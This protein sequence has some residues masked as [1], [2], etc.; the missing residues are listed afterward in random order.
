MY[1]V[2]M[3]VW[4]GS[5]VLAGPHRPSAAVAAVAAAACSVVLQLW[6]LIPAVKARRPRHAG[7]L[8][9]AFA[10]INLAA[11]PVI[12]ALW[13]AAGEQLAVL[14]AVYLAPRW[15]VPAVAA[16]TAAPTAMAL[17]GHD[18]ASDR[19]FAQ[20]TPYWALTMGLL[21][22]LARTAARLRAGQQ[23]LAGSAVV[24]E[25][26]RIDEELRVAL[27][28]ELE[29][30]VA[31]GQHAAR[32]AGDD[33]VAAERELRALTAASRRALAETRRMVSRYQTIT[34]RS[35]VTAAVALLAAAGIPVSVDVPSAVLGQA[36]DSQRAAGFRAALTAVLRDDEAHPCVITAD[37]GDGDVRPAI[38]SR[39]RSRL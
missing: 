34:V 28:A 18:Q 14:A 12:G 11:F 9:A 25:R 37:G 16:L 23:E 27:G 8:I 33:P 6:L 21:I 36:L 26:V 29:Q 3:P 38:R 17:A 5:R 35:E 7:W 22:W 1:A 32:T 19:Y 13:F 39:H 2:A 20:N 10:L 31:A 15:S 4:S 30:L 24:A